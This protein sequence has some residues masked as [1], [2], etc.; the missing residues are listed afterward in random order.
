MADLYPSND[1]SVALWLGIGSL[2][3]RKRASF[4]VGL[5]VGVLSPALGVIL[6]NPVF[7][8]L[9]GEAPLQFG[10][11]GLVTGMLV[12]LAARAEG[13]GLGEAA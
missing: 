4:W 10:A 13:W 5:A 12:W 1:V 7:I 9:L 8:F 11:V 6:V 3:I 2:F